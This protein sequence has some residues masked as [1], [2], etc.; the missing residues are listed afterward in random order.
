MLVLG[1]PARADIAAGVE[2]YDGGDLE[3]AFASFHAG[4]I[5]GDAS[6][7]VALAGLYQ[8]GEGVARSDAAA[9]K[10]YLRAARLG[11]AVAQINLAEAYAAGRGVAPSAAWAPRP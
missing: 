6:A 9:A 2:A 1:A 7:Q 4:A 8:F 10:W 11:D 5:A 3:A